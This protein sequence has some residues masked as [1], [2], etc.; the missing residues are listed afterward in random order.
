MK[1][2]FRN[3]ALVGAGLLLVSVL[4]GAVLTGVFW[5]QIVE[6]R[7]EFT[8]EIGENIRYHFDGW[9]RDGVHYSEKDANSS[10][11][12]TVDGNVMDSVTAL[13]FEIAVGDISIV[14]GDTMSI[15]VTDMIDGT[16]TSEVENGVWYI[17]DS[18]LHSG[19]TYARYE[20]QIEITIPADCSLSRAAIEIAAAKVVAEKLS[21]DVVSLDVGAGSVKLT[22]LQANESCKIKVGAG[23]L[24]VYSFD[25]K[26]IS[27]ENGVGLVY[28]SGRITGNNKV[29]C[30]IG[31]VEIVLTDREKIDFS[32]SIDCSIGEVKVGNNTYSGKVKDSDYN[33]DVEDYFDLKCSIGQITLKTK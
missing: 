31:S 21:A 9:N 25:G 7:D 29:D 4:L 26:N 27:V 20:P 1:H 8:I 14:E 30:G 28:I 2:F 3:I 12:F 15:T 23:E 22:G 17:R 33:K 6:N 32:Y 19:S 16:I 24:K 18:L 10:Y 5:E 11:S 13:D